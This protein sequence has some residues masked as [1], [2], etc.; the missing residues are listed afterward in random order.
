M[1]AYAET[2]I[3]KAMATNPHFEGFTVKDF[4]VLE[5]ATLLTWRLAGVA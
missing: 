5:N 1:E 4:A 2:D 3:F